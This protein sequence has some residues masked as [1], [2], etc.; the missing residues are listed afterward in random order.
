MKKL[1]SV[2]L[3]MLM[4]FLVTACNEKKEAEVTALKTDS[5]RLG[6]AL[7]ADIGKSFKANGMAVDY[8][9]FYQGFKDSMGEK[10]A[11]LLSADEIKMIQKQAITRMRQRIGERQKAAAEEN[12]K[13]GE[14]FFAENGKKEGVVTTKSGL[15]YKIIE[16]GDGP[17]PGIK[18]RVKVDYSGTLLDGTEFDSSYKRGKPAEFGVTGVISGWTEALQL[19]PVGSKWRLF[20]PGKLAYGPRG[21]GKLIGANASLIFD[22][23]LHEILPEKAAPK[24]KVSEPKK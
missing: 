15:Q 8:P 23:K 4:C 24:A 2:I 6:Y 21:A 13:K 5:E 22:V 14:T 17:I 19:M 16:K 3:I 18:D 9:A 12:L 7:G 20:V 10:E 11:L 1:V